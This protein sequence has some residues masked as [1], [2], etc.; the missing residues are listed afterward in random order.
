[1]IRPTFVEANY[2]VLESLLGERKR[3]WCN[4]DLRIKLEYFSEEQKERVVEFEDAPNKEG[5]R[6][7][8]NDEGGRPLGQ[9]AEDN[10]PHG[11]SLPP[12][13]AAH[14][15]RSENGQ[16]L[17]SSLTSVHRGRHPSTNIRGILP[18]NGPA[19]PLEDF[20][21]ITPIEDMLRKPPREAASLRLMG[22]CTPRVLKMPSHVGSYDRKGDPDN[23]LH[24]FEGAIASR[25][26]LRRHIS[27]YITSSRRKEKALELSLL[28][29]REIP[30]GTT[31]KGK[32][33]K[34]DFP[35]IVELTTD[36]SPNYHG[37]DTN[38]CR[39]LRHHIEKAMK[40]GQLSH[41]VK[42]IKKGKTKVSNTQQSDRK[43]ENK[44][45]TPVEAPILMISRQDHTQKRKSAKE[46][47]NGLGDITFPPVTGA[48]NSFDPVIIIA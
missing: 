23:F 46:P 19:P 33:T 40:S 14:L 13:L 11:M 10:G 26:S 36:C 17:Q 1:M 25:R 9:R 2:K 7:E 42:G 18:P 29:S 27:Q 34:T 21:P 3:Q 44:E 28:D 22:S 5:S 41:L 15:L 43:K 4:E 47:I 24:L 32:E 37:H 12:L 8:R 35:H 38:D 20:P 30:H 45:T 6:V 48:N 39:Q 16:P 31:T